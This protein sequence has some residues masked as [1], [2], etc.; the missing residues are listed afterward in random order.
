VCSIF[1]HYNDSP[2]FLLLPACYLL[3]SSKGE[4]ELVSTRVAAAHY[5]ALV[6]V[7]FIGPELLVIDPF[8]KVGV[9]VAIAWCS[10]QRRYLAR[11][12]LSVAVVLVNT[13]AFFRILFETIVEYRWSFLM[14]SG[15]ALIFG[16]SCVERGARRAIK[17]WRVPGT[18]DADS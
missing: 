8:V 7:L 9:P 12:F 17:Y 13:E 3:M 4:R 16:A 1:G 14:V 11:L 10:V 2:Y 15:I 5:V 6:A 18:L